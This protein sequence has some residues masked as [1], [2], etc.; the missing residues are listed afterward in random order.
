MK[1]LLFTILATFILSA[2]SYNPFSAATTPASTN[3][4]IDIAIP[5]STTAPVNTS[6]PSTNTDLTD[7]NNWTAIQD[8]PD[9]GIITKREGDQKN[10]VFFIN[11]EIA[12][13]TIRHSSTN[14]ATMMAEILMEKDPQ[15]DCGFVGSIWATNDQGPNPQVVQTYPFK[16]DSFIDKGIFTDVGKGVLTLY[17]SGNRVWISSDHSDAMMSTAQYAISGIQAQEYL[18]VPSEYF[19]IVAVKNNQLIILATKKPLADNIALLTKYGV[20][21]GQMFVIDTY[22]QAGCFAMDWWKWNNLVG[23]AIFVTAPDN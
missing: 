11:P 9:Q 14:T 17:V 12:K 16:E 23:S 7:L 20:D 8:Y 21:P 19:Q 4:S 13:V 18:D 2:C 3:V 10:Y 6:V 22:P 1:R 5:V 15:A